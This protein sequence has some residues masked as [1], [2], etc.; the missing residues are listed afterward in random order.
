MYG[1]LLVSA[2]FML[3]MLLIWPWTA[4]V[5]VLPALL[6]TL[7]ALALGIWILRHNRIGNFNVRPELKSGAQLI[8]DGPYALV[9]H[10]MYVAVLWL[11]LCAVVLYASTVALLLLG[12]LYLVLDRKAALEES[13]LRIHFAD[14]EA[15]AEKV[16]RFLPRRLPG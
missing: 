4:P 10:P 14:Y 15:Y 6:L 2:Q 5:F 1:R 11:G 7:P 13:Y 16:G 12:L 3:I 8:I 9:R